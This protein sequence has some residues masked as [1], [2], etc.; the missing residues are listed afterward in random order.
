MI[1]K[2]AHLHLVD[3]GEDLIVEVTIQDPRL[4][5]EYS[6]SF[7]GGSVRN[8]HHALGT[9]IERYP[10]LCG[11]VSATVKVDTLT[12]PGYDPGKASAN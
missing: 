5:G 9:I 1:I 11:E 6:F 12:V 7:L 4:E 3:G 2:T 8:L 10:E